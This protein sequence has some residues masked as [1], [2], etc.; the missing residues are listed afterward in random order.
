MVLNRLEVEGV[1][2]RLA[3]LKKINEKIILQIGT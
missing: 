2:T 1:L 3:P